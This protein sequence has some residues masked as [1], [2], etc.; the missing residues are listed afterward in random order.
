M[1]IAIIGAMEEE[2]TLLREKIV[3]KNTET[4]AGSEFT[5][6]K[7][8]GADVCLLRSGIGK[9]NAAMTTTIL[10]HTFK[11]DYVINTGS[12]GGSD[13]RLNVGDIVISSE[14][15]HHDVDVTAF[16]YEYGQVPGLPPAFEADEKL[17]QLAETAFLEIGDVQVVK[18]LIATGDSFMNDPERMKKLK[19]I[20]PNLLAVEMEGAA[21]A[22]VCHQFETPFV[23]IRALSDIA[24]K[25]SNISFN[26]FLEKAALHSATMVMNIVQE[27]SRKN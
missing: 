27:L 1:K 11:P 20:F 24:G 7:M 14:V 12:A 19:E 5:K 9:V 21:I 2:V 18:G 22:Q 3:M 15:R 6:G 8:Y 17:V 23:V 16:H 4:I 10:L 26:Q 25:E 13:E